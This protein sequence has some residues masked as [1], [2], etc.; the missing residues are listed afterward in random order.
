MEYVHGEPMDRYCDR[1]QLDLR[2]RLNLFLDICAAVQ[3][4]HQNLIVHRDLKPGNILV[5]AEGAPKLLDFGI[6]KLLD[7]GDSRSR[8]GADAH[9]RSAA[10]AGVRQPRTDS[11]PPR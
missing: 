10:H 2:A 1:E 9:E 8:A 4:A 11:R 5:T 6:A 7:T 3:Y